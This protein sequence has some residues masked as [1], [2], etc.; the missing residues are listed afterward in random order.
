MFCT[1][2]PTDSLARICQQAV[3]DNP[4]IRQR[5]GKYTRI[6]K[7]MVDVQY[8]TRPPPT[9]VRQGYVNVA[10]LEYTSLLTTCQAR[11]R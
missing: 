1:Y 6:V 7:Y 5:Y 8:P 10:P 3:E 2:T 9:F 11:D 4:V